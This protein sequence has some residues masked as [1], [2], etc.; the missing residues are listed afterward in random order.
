LVFRLYAINRFRF[1]GPIAD[2][3]AAAGAFCFIDPVAL[4]DLFL[5]KA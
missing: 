1:D 5:M 2:A 3:G 4:R